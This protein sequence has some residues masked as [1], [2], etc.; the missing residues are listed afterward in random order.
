MG[1]RCRVQT[2]I[3]PGIDSL[4]RPSVIICGHLLRILLQIFPGYVSP[5]EG[6]ASLGIV[7]F[8]AEID[9]S[10]AEPLGVILWRFPQ[11]IYKT[12]VSSSLLHS[13]KLL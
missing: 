1:M 4:D 7:T 11:A 13:I 9:E 5:S 10:A 12:T 2:L 6:N 3:L 8:K